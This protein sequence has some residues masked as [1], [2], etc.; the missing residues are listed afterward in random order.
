MDIRMGAPVDTNDA[1]PSTATRRFLELDPL[2]KTLCVGVG[3]PTLLVSVD[4]ILDELAASLVVSRPAVTP[5]TEC[6]HAAASVPQEVQASL[7][8]AGSPVM[9]T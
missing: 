2:A 4:P 7:V 1:S 6:L 5:A 9:A 8:D 3:P